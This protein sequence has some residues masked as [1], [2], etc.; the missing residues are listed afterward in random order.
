MLSILATATEPDITTIVAQMRKSDASSMP[1]LAPGNSLQF[2]F[3]EYAVIVTVVATTL[4]IVVGAGVVVG[5]GMEHIPSIWRVGNELAN[6][7]N[8]D[9]EVSL[10]GREEAFE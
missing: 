1:V 7:R 4:P 10:G 5:V 6:L 3:H 2:S 9:V 8:Y